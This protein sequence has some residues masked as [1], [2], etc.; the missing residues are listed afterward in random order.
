MR[1]QFSVAV[2]IKAVI[3]TGG[4]RHGPHSRHLLPGRRRTLW[5][6]VPCGVAGEWCSRGEGGAG[7]RGVF[8]ATG[9]VALYWVRDFA[10]YLRIDTLKYVRASGPLWGVERVAM[11]M[12]PPRCARLFVQGYVYGQ[13]NGACCLL[14]LQVYRRFR[15]AFKF[16]G[17]RQWSPRPQPRGSGGVTTPRKDTRGEHWRCPAQVPSGC[18]VSFKV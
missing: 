9:L 7:C 3:T 10:A 18:R 17:Y 15:G 6:V 13:L 11:A 12:S 4:C 2:Y 1:L 8:S 16:N 5:F 14:S